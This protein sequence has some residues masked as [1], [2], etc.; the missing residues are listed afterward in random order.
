[1]RVNDACYDCHQDKEGPFVFEHAPVEESCANC[2]RPH[3]SAA[4]NL[5]TLGEPALCLQCHEFHFHSGLLSPDGEV[6]VGGSERAN[7]YGAESMN[8]AFSTKCT[9][10]HSQVHGSNHPSGSSQLR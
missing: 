10:C 1:M 3:G 2:H 8:V 5:L 6:E 9:Q 7:P 4:N